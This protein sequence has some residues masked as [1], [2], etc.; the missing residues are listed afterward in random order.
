MKKKEDELQGLEKKEEEEAG[1]QDWDDLMV[2]SFEDSTR[3]FRAGDELVELTADQ[4][5]FSTKEMTLNAGKVLN[6]S[7]NVQICRNSVR[8]MTDCKPG[9]PPLPFRTTF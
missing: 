3:I 6:N 5:K 8:F 4:T 2:L 1:D 9:P 7:R